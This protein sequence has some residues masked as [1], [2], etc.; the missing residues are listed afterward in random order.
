MHCVACGFEWEIAGPVYDQSGCPKCRSKKS[1]K[2]AV[3]FFGQSA[4]KYEVLYQAVEALRKIDT[5]VVVG[6]SG[7][8]LPADE[9][10]ARSD[11]FSV[12]VNLESGSGMNEAA[13]SACL[14]GPAT[15]MLPELTDVI[16]EHM[17]VKA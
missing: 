14:F 1:V 6:T 4:P 12:L 17:E 7:A 13:F 10:F 9:L 15:L 5:V 11:A 3:V 16:A 2:P 8:V